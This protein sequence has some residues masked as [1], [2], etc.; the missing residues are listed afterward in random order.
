MSYA[1][2]TT[3][4]GGDRRILDNIQ[5][6][7]LANYAWS[8]VIDPEQR[9]LLRQFIVQDFFS[10]EEQIKLW[11]AANLQGEIA[12]AEKIMENGTQ[13]TVMVTDFVRNSAFRRLILYAYDNRCS[14][15]GLRITTP[16]GQSPIDAAHL[17]PWSETHDDSPTNGMA[18]CK[19]HHWA[20]DADMISPTPDLRWAVSPLLDPRRDSEHEL[21]RFEGAPI[22]LPREERYYPRSEAISWR[23]KMLFR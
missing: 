9:S 6:A 12:K 21:T 22:L 1:K 3:S 15:C 8:V 2:L 19:L 16:S 10:M 13:Y 14:M 17:I 5:Y 18:L 11:Q 23:R 7:F 4:G 20:L